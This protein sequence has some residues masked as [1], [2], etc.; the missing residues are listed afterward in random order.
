MNKIVIDN[1][2]L[3]SK[4]DHCSF[5]ELIKKWTN[6]Q[7][8]SDNEILNYFKELLLKLNLHISGSITNVEGNSFYYNN[9]KFSLDKNSKLT[10]KIDNGIIYTYSI[11][12]NNANT[13]NDIQDKLVVNLVATHLHSNSLNF[14][15]TYEYTDHI[16]LSIE[17]SRANIWISILIP[18]LSL[19]IPLKNIL[20]F[21]N[22][23][24]DRL[25]LVRV[26]EILLKVKELF[27]YNIS[28]SD[29]YLLPNTFPHI[30]V[31]Y[32]NEFEYLEVE[33]MQGVITK[34]ISR[35]EYPNDS[36]FSYVFE[37]IET[38]NNENNDESTQESYANFCIE[39]S[40]TKVNI[41]IKDIRFLNYFSIYTNKLL[42][43]SFLKRLDFNSTKNLY[44]KI[45]NFL[46]YNL[47]NISIEYLY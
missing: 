14:I 39:N 24:L 15:A 2:L 18:S 25:N 10:L 40:H 38:D 4:K 36:N 11:F 16:S 35:K 37:M 33:C 12:F 6:F 42:F 5:L 9:I 44:N 7:N 20:E 26:D 45:F 41:L 3:F 46:G 30:E 34:T 22:Y 21:E 32:G 27:N 8:I 1:A 13:T 31:E 28:L 29:P 43:E 47:D 19:N 23:L 17:L